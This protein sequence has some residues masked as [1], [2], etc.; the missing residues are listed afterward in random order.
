MS[1]QSET[2]RCCVWIQFV[3]MLGITAVEVLKQLTT[4]GQ[5]ERGSSQDFEYDFK[6]DL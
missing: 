1:L 3:F 4:G 5:E 6:S 2:K